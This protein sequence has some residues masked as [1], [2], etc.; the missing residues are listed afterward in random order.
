VGDRFDLLV[1][2]CKLILVIL[3]EKRKP[4]FLYNRI[5]NRIDITQPPRS[6]REQI[7]R[8]SLDQMSQNRYV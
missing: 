6:A 8:A 1:I 3:G 2:F 7:A 4:L 5:L